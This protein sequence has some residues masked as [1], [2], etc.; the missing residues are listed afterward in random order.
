MAKLS[1]FLSRKLHNGSTSLEARDHQS[2]S[3]LQA[4]RAEQARS[5]GYPPETLDPS[6]SKNVRRLESSTCCVSF[7]TR[8]TR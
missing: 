2:V 7:W 5:P 1:G 6:R 3:D 4:T 8:G